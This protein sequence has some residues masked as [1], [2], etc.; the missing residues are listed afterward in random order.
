MD[1]VGLC[2]GHSQV[3]RLDKNPFVISRRFVILAFDCSCCHAILIGLERRLLIGG[4]NRLGIKAFLYT[5]RNESK[6][7]VLTKKLCL[8]DAECFDIVSITFV[9]IKEFSLDDSRALWL[10][11]HLNRQSNKYINKS[12]AK[13]S[14]AHQPVLFT[15]GSVR[16]A[17][18]PQ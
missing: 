15:S 13:S 12:W 9:T 10:I 11:I 18:N 5:E 3:N 8:R 17:W 6:K 2:I 16:C 7:R 1:H 14:K 4:L